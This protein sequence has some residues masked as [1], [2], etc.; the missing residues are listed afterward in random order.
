MSQESE[1]SNESLYSQFETSSSSQE[2]ETPLSSQDSQESQPN[3]GEEDLSAKCENP[4]QIERTTTS[5][6][7]HSQDNT[8]EPSQPDLNWSQKS[9]QT[10]YNESNTQITEKEATSQ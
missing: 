1:S 9:Q 10:Q 8:Q 7:N 4:D 2:I 3:H 5:L 6:G